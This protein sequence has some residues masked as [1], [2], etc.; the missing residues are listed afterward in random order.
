MGALPIHEC[1][2]HIAQGRKRQ[3]DLGGL[4][5][6]LARSSGLALPLGARQVHQ[7]EL[8]HSEVL[9]TILALL[10]ALDGDGEDGM[11]S[12]AVGVHVG[13]PHTAV[14][15][16]NG[17]DLVHVIGIVD[18]ESREVFDIHAN[19][20]PLLHVQAESLIL[21]E[22]ISN[23]LVVD[24]QIRHPD[25][26]LDILLRLGDVT[27][28]VGKGIGDDALHL[29]AGSL[30]L[31]GEGLARSSLTIREDGS[32]VALNHVF[33]NGT[34]HSIVHVH[35]GGVG[36]KDIVEGKHFGWTL[37]GEARAEGT[38]VGLQLDLAVDVIHLDHRGILGLSLLRVQRPDS[39][40]NFDVVVLGL[41][42]TRDFPPAF[43]TA[44]DTVALLT[45]VFLAKEV[46][47]ILG[48]HRYPKNR[49][50][51]SRAILTEKG[52]CKEV[53]VFRREYLGVTMSK[54][55]APISDATNNGRIS[56]FLF[57]L[58]NYEKNVSRDV[59]RSTAYRK[60]AQT[61]AAHEEQIQSGS[62]AKK[63]RGVGQKIA[64]KIDEFL[65]TGKLKKL[66]K[67]RGNDSNVAIGLL[68]RVSGI[69]PA[70]ARELVEAGILTIEALRERED[71]LN[72]GQKIGLKHFED[73]E[74]RVAR[75]EIEAIEQTILKRLGREEKITICGSF[76]RGLPNSGDI[77][78]LLTHDS[79]TS[80]KSAKAH[81]HL[82]KTLVS[83]LKGLITDTISLG[84]SK[85]MG[86]CRLN[87]DDPYR[88]LDI[89]LVPRDQFYC[90]VLYFTGSDL[91]NKNMRAHALD[92]GF[93]LNEYT[94]RPIDCAHVAE[95]ALPISCEEDIFDYISYHYKEPSERTL[96]SVPAIEPG[97]VPL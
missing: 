58:S 26:E 78:V 5:E 27:K 30:A 41:L 81:G 35:L 9:L 97:N 88:R 33:H 39:D 66:E 21:A 28:D 85:F 23:L 96:A 51:D 48:L 59:H 15:V 57:E 70:K 42:L 94:L 13:G 82:L 71:L 3:V 90:A 95:A 68:T 76:R 53:C 61:I 84:D 91:F 65:S 62:Q 54:R 92:Q 29:G 46:M 8:A 80:D 16:A 86:V 34:S 50:Q 12:G 74:K 72:A 67:I 87:L 69:G 11:A 32:I 83:N 17:H 73:F 64:E 10:G 31:H 93:T 2:Y 44:L 37:A 45:F 6:P 47:V 56:E 7:M 49:S 40:H 43:L 77:D 55:K 60:A 25:Q 24:F 20:R 52:E 4:L 14:L 18:H 89:R 19:V 38:H 75:P 22:E 63:I 36:P 1:R 79:Y